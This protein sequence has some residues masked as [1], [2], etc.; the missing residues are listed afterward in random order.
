MAE[1]YV[2]LFSLSFSGA[3]MF[4]L[5]LDLF[6]HTGFIN[7]PR[8]IL[9]HN[10]CHN[11][12]YR[13]TTGIYVMLAMVIVLTILAF[14]WQYYWNI[15]LMHRYFGVNVVPVK[16]ETVTAAKSS[17][18][19]TAAG[20][21]VAAVSEKV[22]T[23]HH[24]EVVVLS[25]K[26]PTSHHS[27]IIAVPTHKSHS[28]HSAPLSVIRE[29]A[30]AI[31]SG[32]PSHHTSHHTSPVVTSR[33]RSVVE[34]VAPSSHHTVIS[35]SR[36]SGTI[37]SPSHHSGGLLSG[38]VAGLLSGGG[39]NGGPLAASSRHSVAPTATR[40]ARGTVLPVPSVAGS[41]HTG[42]AAPLESVHS[43]SKSGNGSHHTSHHTSHHSLA[44]SMIAASRS[45]A[46]SAAASGT[47]SQHSA[48]AYLTHGQRSGGSAQ[49]ED[50]AISTSTTIRS[51]QPKPPSSKKMFGFIP[52]VY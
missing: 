26:A 17:H 25:E 6:V 18:T 37:V 13:I 16:A 3:Y 46:A 36:R 38:V 9:D 4:V 49:P 2:I 44:P 43:A 11:I 52:I 51:E 23:S 42:S 8:S 10:P 40:S 22:P 5:G 33:A 19:P 24:S 32:G 7:G 45:A 39:S 1:R 21:V 50:D 29:N 30:S 34:S 47:K 31:I 48:S 12:T 27:E 41:H 14:G 28:H 15:I 35:P 20:T